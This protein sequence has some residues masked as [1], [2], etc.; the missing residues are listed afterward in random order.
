MKINKIN[1]WENNSFSIE[2]IKISALS[3]FEFG[4]LHSIANNIKIDVCNTLYYIRQKIR[5]STVMNTVQNIDFVKITPK[6]K[7]LIELQIKNIDK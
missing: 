3:S 2:N 4:M 1:L 7:L 5:N 6:T